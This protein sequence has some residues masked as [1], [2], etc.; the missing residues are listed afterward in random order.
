MPINATT[1]ISTSNALA[2]IREATRQVRDGKAPSRGVFAQITDIHDSR[3]DRGT[4]AAQRIDQAW[5][6]LQAANSS[7][8]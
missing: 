2:M 4:R 8:S 1:E 3:D 5:K 7:R 6:A